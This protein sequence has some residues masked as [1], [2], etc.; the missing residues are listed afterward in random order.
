MVAGSAST[1][2]SPNLGTF[3]PPPRTHSKTC[4]AR[5]ADRLVR[6]PEQG[7]RMHIREPAGAVPFAQNARV[8]QF[9][10]QIRAVP[11]TVF[12]PRTGSADVPG[13]P[14]SGIPARK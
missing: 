8:P 1:Q 6:F 2:F 10:T 12:S 3:L 14:A 7:L 5:A 4:T 9:P 11:V 13:S